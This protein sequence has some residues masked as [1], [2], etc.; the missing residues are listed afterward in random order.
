MTTTS[1]STLS[2]VDAMKMNEALKRFQANQNLAYHILSKYYPTYVQDEDLKQDALLG[3]WQACLTFEEG[4]AKFSTY[5]GKCITNSIR[6]TLRHRN[7]VPETLSLDQPMGGGDNS[8]LSEVIEDTSSSIDDGIICFKEF[9][10]TLTN[11]ER[12]CVQM[13][14]KGYSQVDIAKKL[15]VTRSYVNQ[16]LREMRENYN[17]FRREDENE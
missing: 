14:L 16:I 7:K 11:L 3:L 12:Y 1:Q 5:A 8:L 9:W 4:K 17:E 6:I 13:R 15:G 10:K 2:G